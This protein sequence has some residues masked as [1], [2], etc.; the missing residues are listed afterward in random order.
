MEDV[1]RGWP[2]YSSANNLEKVSRAEFGTVS[3]KSFTEGLG[4]ATSIGWVDGCRDPIELSP[5]S[6]LFMTKSAIKN[7]AKW[8]HSLR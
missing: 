7:L 4:S 2:V 1:R 5:G 6:V 3:G 8:L